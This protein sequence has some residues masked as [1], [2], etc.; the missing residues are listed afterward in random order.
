MYGG[1]NNRDRETLRKS[2]SQEE[3][4]FNMLAGTSKVNSQG[5]VGSFKFELRRKVS[6]LEI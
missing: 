1:G 5:T 6:R 2:R 4:A 3:G